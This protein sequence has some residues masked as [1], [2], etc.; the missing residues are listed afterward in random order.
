MKDQK[1]IQSQNPV[2]LLHFIRLNLILKEKVMIIFSKELKVKTCDRIYVYSLD[3]IINYCESLRRKIEQII[4]EF[5]RKRKELIDR[6]NWSS[7]IGTMCR[8]EDWLLVKTFSSLVYNKILKENIETILS[9]FNKGLIQKLKGGKS[10]MSTP[11]Q[12]NISVL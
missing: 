2:F 10:K 3:E 1:T 11:H 4:D 7:E 9:D 5:T 6:Y 8:K 12:L